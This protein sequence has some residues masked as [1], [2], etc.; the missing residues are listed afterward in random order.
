MDT[1]PSQENR[2]CIGCNDHRSLFVSF[3]LGSISQN[4][5]SREA[6]YPTRPARQYSHCCYHYRRQNS[7]GQHPR[8]DKLGSRSC[9]FNGPW[10]SG[11][12]PAVQHSSIRG[13]L[14]HKSQKAIQIQTT[15]FHT[16]QQDPRS[17]MRS[18]SHTGKL[19][20]KE[21]L[22]RTTAPHTLFRYHQP[23]PFD[24]SYKQLSAIR[25]NDSRSL[26][27]PLASRTLLPLD[28]AAPENKGFLRNFGK[29]RKNS[30]MDRNFHLCTGRYY[31]KAS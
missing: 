2:L 5:S 11:F 27:M 26:S 28:Q 6:A 24:I 1:R 18:D 15:Y 4:Q 10:I 30:D 20:S 8:S 7:R 19:L 17:E 9:L 31:Q 29:C 3:P 13:F 16:C 25:L 12:L 22:S 23:E 14:R 21:R